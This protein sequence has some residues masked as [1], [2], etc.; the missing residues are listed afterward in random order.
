MGLL[1][2][3]LLKK[4]LTLCLMWNDSVSLVLPGLCSRLFG[5]EDKVNTTSSKLVSC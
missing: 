3:A 2:C 1:H 5:T 4:H